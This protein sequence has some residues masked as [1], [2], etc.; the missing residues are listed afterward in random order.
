M[1]Q[2]SQLIGGLAGERVRWTEDSNNFSDMKKRLV[3][4]CA[5]SCAFVCYTGPFNQ[6]FRKYMIEDKFIAD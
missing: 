4:D 3:G 5:A 1:N 2:A 6:E